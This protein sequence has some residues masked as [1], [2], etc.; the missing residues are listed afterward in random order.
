MESKLIC[1]AL[2]LMDR[3]FNRVL[4]KYYIRWNPSL[5]KI[6]YLHKDRDIHCLI[7]LEFVFI[8]L[9][10]IVLS[11]GFLL[12]QIISPKQSNSPVHIILFL[13]F[14]EISLFSCLV[15]I[16]VSRHKKEF[17][18]VINQLPTLQGKLQTGTF[19]KNCLR[20]NKSKKLVLGVSYLQVCFYSISRNCS[21]KRN[22]LGGNISACIRAIFHKFGLIVILCRVFES[23]SFI[24]FSS[25]LHFDRNI[26]F[27]QIHTSPAGHV[28]LSSTWT[29]S[30]LNSYIFLLHIYN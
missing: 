30:N 4:W 2:D 24:S 25:G 6:T 18:H 27:V 21:T 26:E 11:S 19:Y 7:A 29:A 15:S 10:G 14:L 13:T 1:K 8:F 22:R 17:S 12:M 3:M 28:S 20:T 16:Y 23:G 9:N 5:Q